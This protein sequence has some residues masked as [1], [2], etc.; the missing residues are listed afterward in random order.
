VGELNANC[1]AK[2]MSEDGT[3]EITKRGPAGR[4]ELWI[5]A[6]NVMKGYWNN[7][8]ATQEILTH[9]GWLRSGD[10]VYVDEHGHFFIVDRI[11]ELIKA[12]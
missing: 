7:A 9:D 8:K 11:K 12:S 10:I 5:R 6:P 2:I 4:G 1:E 3:H